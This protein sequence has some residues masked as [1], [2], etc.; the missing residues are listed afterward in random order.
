MSW[1]FVR[2]LTASGRQELLRQQYITAWRKR[3]EDLVGRDGTQTYYDE[4]E[5]AHTGGDNIK[6]NPQLV[7]LIHEIGDNFFPLFR[8]QHTEDAE[9]Y[10]ALKDRQTEY[11]TALYAKQSCQRMQGAG[12]D[13]PTAMRLMA[14]VFRRSIKA[15][16]DVTQYV[17]AVPLYAFGSFENNKPG[18]S[19]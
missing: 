9:G 8:R 4:W 6:G 16:E 13:K 2:K 15:Y 19:R 1:D 3:A 17:A 18:A 12:L 5:I 11:A 14:S 7:M 10:S